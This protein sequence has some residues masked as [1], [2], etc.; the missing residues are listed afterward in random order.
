MY[1]AVYDQ[2]P[3]CVQRSD[4]VATPQMLYW[5]CETGWLVSSD[6]TCPCFPSTGTASTP[7][8][9]CFSNVS[10]GHWTQALLLEGL[11]LS[12]QSHFFRPC[13]HCFHR[14]SF[15]PTCSHLGIY[16]LDELSQQDCL[17]CSL[18]VDLVRHTY[19]DMPAG[20]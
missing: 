5:L 6:I 11:A 10:S 14:I 4:S 16:F 19:T 1:V 20:I 12:Q 17:C 9:S 15:R 13:S 8:C 2:V 3:L 7:Y 18:C